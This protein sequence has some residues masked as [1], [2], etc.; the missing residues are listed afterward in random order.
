MFHLLPPSI[1]SSSTVTP[2][3]VPYLVVVVHN[4]SR[5]S[6]TSEHPS[7][8]PW[9]QSDGYFWERH[10]VGTSQDVTFPVTNARTYT[11]PVRHT[12]SNQV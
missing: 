9:F 1:S 6:S 8:R 5:R 2:G 3:R 4:E 11:R 10:M 7:G 12:S